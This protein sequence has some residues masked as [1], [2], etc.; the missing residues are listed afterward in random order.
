MPLE[1]GLQGLRIGCVTGRGP[2]RVSGKRV[3][4]VKPAGEGNRAHP[5]FLDYFGDIAVMAV[6]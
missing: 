2:R 4:P 3:D 6:Q 1:Q 5:D